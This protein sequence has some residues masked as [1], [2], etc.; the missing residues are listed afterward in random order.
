[1]LF[2]VETNN[3]GLSTGPPER[4]KYHRNV[5]RA[6]SSALLVKRFQRSCRLCFSSSNFEQEIPRYAFQ[7]QSV[8]LAST[9]SMPLARYYRIILY[10]GYAQSKPVFLPACGFGLSLHAKMFK[11]DI[12]PSEFSEVTTP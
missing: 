2:L 10:Q 5:P 9:I 7:D 6:L 3:P 12:F 11:Q 1:M 4:L 8:A